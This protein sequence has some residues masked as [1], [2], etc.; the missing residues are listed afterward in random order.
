MQKTIYKV[1]W[2]WNY[3]KEE[4][5]LNEMSAKG[6]QLVRV[7]ICKYVFEEAARGEYVYKLELLENMP[8]HIESVKYIQFL[9][10]TGVEYMGSLNRWVY[11]R[12]KKSEGAFELYSDIGSRQKHNQRIIA[13]LGVILPI[14][15]FWFGV[16]FSQYLSKGVTV[17]LVLA[18][19]QF[20]FLLFVSQGMYQVLKQRSALKKTQS[21]QE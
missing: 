20:L 10:E 18:S 21:I 19:L 15:L 16:T 8:S 3:E 4:K 11:F 2:A 6:F 1:F 5:W 7:G 17:Q 14:A 12:K 9:E 13:L